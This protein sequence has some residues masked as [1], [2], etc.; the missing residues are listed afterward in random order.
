MGAEGAKR[1]NRDEFFAKL[2]PLDGE[3][4]RKVLWN[5]YWRGSAP[6]RERIEGELDP[7]EKVQRR[8]AGSEPP[9]P[10]EVLRAVTE[11]TELAGSGAY[12]AGDRR[13]SRGER[14]KWR[15]TFRQ[16]ATDAQSALHAADTGPAEEAMQLMIDLACAASSGGLFHS[17]DPLEAARFVVSHAAGALWQTVLSEHGFDEFAERAAPQLISWESAYGWTRG[18]GKVCEHETSLAEVLTGMLSTPQQWA[19]FADAYF[20]A[21][22]TVARKEAVPKADRWSH[23]RPDYTRAERTRNLAAWNELLIGQLD[24]ER[25]DVLVNHRSFGGNE[26]VFLRARVAQLRGDVAGA[27]K[28]A[29]EGLASLPG[30]QGFIQIAVET[31]AELPR[32]SREMLQEQERV[33]VLIEGGD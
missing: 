14:S 31:G 23:E 10:H 4:L 19:A 12:M 29:E 5:V 28:L 21:L 8:R 24:D 18:W 30:H 3:Q 27:R 13:V 2:A 11:F 33:R 26:L 9:D 6:V 1:M 16:L 22:D 7:A 15:V 20:A 32:R 25:V 17:E